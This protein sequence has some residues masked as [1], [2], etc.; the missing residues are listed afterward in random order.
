MKKILN[1]VMSALYNI[2]QNKAYTLFC[3]IGTAITFVFIIIMLQLMYTLVGNVPPFVNAD[4]T[5]VFEILKTFK[6]EK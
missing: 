2:T 5:I 4:R 6:V 3:V 1:N